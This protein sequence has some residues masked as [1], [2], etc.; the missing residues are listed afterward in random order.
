MHDNGLLLVGLQVARGLGF[1]P[2]AL[3]RVHDRVGLGEEG[4]ADSL[5][6]DRVLAKGGQHLWKSHQRLHA[7]VPGLVGDLFDCGIT[8]DVRMRL[9]PGNRVGDIAWIG[10]GHQHLSQQSV[11]IQRQR[12]KHL[13]KLF[14][15]E[16]RLVWRRR[17]GRY[18][19]YSRCSR[20]RRRGGCLRLRILFGTAKKR[21]YGDGEQDRPVKAGRHDDAPVA[22]K[23]ERNV[24]RP[25]TWL[26]TRQSTHGK[27]FAA[28]EQF[29]RRRKSRGLL[30]LRRAQRPNSRRRRYKVRSLIPR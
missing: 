10:G 3:Y 5:Y 7:R 29:Q 13:I 27:L 20:C 8:T 2:Q 23:T 6:P 15:A 21:E 17:S 4:I 1:S 14:G 19:R 26:P 9:G 16:H 22:E 11:R 24:R 30:F 25:G 12:C 28:G 18:S